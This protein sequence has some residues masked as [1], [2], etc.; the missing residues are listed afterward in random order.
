MAAIK[1]RAL[2]ELAL[3]AREVIN[4]TQADQRVIEMLAYSKGYL[5]HQVFNELRLVEDEE[6]AEVRL[7]EDNELPTEFQYPNC[8]AE[9]GFQERAARFRQ[10][11]T[12]NQ[13]YYYA[14][15]RES[16]SLVEAIDLAKKAG[17]G[18]FIIEDMS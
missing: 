4:S 11:C 18:R 9:P 1:D 8:Y 17:C 10:W 2:R 15:P 7:L 3:S 14:R 12:D 6:M 13:V 16:F 5:L